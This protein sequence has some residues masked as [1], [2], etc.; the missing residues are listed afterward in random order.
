MNLLKTSIYTSSST[1]MTFIS[2][3]I[4]TK[5]VAS[6]IGPEG[7]AYYGQFLNITSVLSTLAT[8]AISAGVVKYVSQ[9]F[10]DKNKQQNVINTSLIIVIVAS[11]LISIFTMSCSGVFSSWAFKGQN[12]WVVFFVYGLCIMAVSMNLISNSILNGLNK[13]RQLTLVSISSSFLGMLSILLS[14]YYLGLE[15]VL[16]SSSFTGI[17]MLLINI[18]MLNKLGITWKPNFKVVDR[19]IFMQLFKYSFMAII[20]GFVVPFMQ[21]MVRNKITNTVSLQGAGYWQ[22]TTRISDYYLSFITSVLSVY[23]L[24]KLSALKKKEDI[25]KEII[26]GYKLI[27]P[28][29]GLLSFSIW[30]SR[31]LI[32]QVVF[33][34]E[35]YGMK[36]LFTFQL[37]GDFLKIG[38]WLLA[39]VMIAK[40]MIYTYIVTEILFAI[41]YVLISYFLVSKFGTI[42]ATYAF[43][44]NYLL[45]WVIMNYFVWKKIKD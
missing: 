22:A 5:V 35:F 15:G 21:I 38:S 1:I 16:M 40:A 28:I 2:G 12:F 11:F 41:N 18:W 29:V 37:I 33:S 44:I 4:V 43:A 25:K 36:N 32:I 10:D 17:A 14:S 34:K 26:S 45:Y 7:M 20:T 9:Y 31:D 24:P 27:L 8:G 42:G 23:Y 19:L 3:F 6:K 39:F 13:I 30:L